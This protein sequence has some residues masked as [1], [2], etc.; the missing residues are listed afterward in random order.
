M[1]RG[2]TT[3]YVIDG[4][5]NTRTAGTSAVDKGRS[6]EHSE[7]GEQ[8]VRRRG[9]DETCASPQRS[10]VHKIEHKHEARA[11][12]PRLERSAERD[13]AAA[14]EDPRREHHLHR[15][16]RVPLNG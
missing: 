8:E 3:Y 13:V 4:M 7:R 14:E 1:M 10:R 11:R 12:H 9:I 6:T 16:A 5:L 15:R 2:V